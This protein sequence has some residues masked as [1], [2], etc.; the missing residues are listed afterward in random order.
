MAPWIERYAYKKRTFLK[1]ISF[2]L[3]LF[4]LAFWKRI[5]GEKPKTDRSAI[6]VLLVLIFASAKIKINKLP[7]GLWAPG[8]HFTNKIS[9]NVA[10]A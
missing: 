5:D 6:E 10:P 8:Q 4:P 3:I 2:S 9:Y 7:W 1:S